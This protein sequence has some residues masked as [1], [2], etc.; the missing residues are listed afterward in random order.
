MTDTAPHVFTPT[1][2]QPPPASLVGPYGWA[3]AHLFSGPFNTLLTVGALYL[4]YVTIPP[5]ID[6]AFISATFSGTTREACVGSDGACWT[7]IK[8]RFDQILYGFYPTDEQW[9]PNLVFFLGIFGLIA[10][11]PKTR[12]RGWLVAFLLLPYPIIS[13]FLLCGGYFGLVEVETARW[14]GLTVTLVVSV[15]GIVA[16][17]PIGIVLALGR[18]SN[19]P[20]VKSACIVFIEVVRGVPLISVLFMASV[21]LPL[22]LPEGVSFN[23]LLRALIGVTLFTAAYMAETV[24]GGL[25]AIPKGQYEGAQALGLG[26]WKM[27]ILIILP[28]ALKIVIPGIVNSFISLFKDTTLVYIVGLF[29]VLEIIRASSKDAN[30]L[31]METEGYAF[32]GLM[33]WVFCFTMSRVSIRIEKRLDTSHRK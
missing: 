16:S 5:V 6:W 28:Q 13:F 7:F 1:P 14:G 23:K 10:L 9:R 17:F 25:Q 3:R 31:G 30:W 32:A 29:D 22:F 4:L 20:I 15:T 24:R 33:F 21:M 27:M 11:V 8:V 12:F 19:M 26:Y 18:R 2:P